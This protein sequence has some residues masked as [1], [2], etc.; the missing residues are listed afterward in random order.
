MIRSQGFRRGPRHF[1][2]LVNGEMCFLEIK[3]VGSWGMVL[4]YLELKGQELHEG[5]R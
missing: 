4:N 5:M 1:N 3:V 2:L